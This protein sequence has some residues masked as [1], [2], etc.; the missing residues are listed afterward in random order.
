MRNEATVLFELFF[1]ERTFNDV[2][3][4]EYVQGYAS[5]FDFIFWRNYFL[6]LT[7]IFTI[8]ITS[9]KNILN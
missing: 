4:L 5:M 9:S 8:N 6:Y 2:Y 1:L 7:D 3:F